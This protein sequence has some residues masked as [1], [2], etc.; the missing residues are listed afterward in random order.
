KADSLWGSVFSPSAACMVGE[1]RRASN[2]GIG[3]KQLNQPYRRRGPMSGHQMLT[4]LALCCLGFTVRAVIG[5][6][7]HHW[8]WYWLGGFVSVGCGYLARCSIEHLARSIA[9][10]LTALAVGHTPRLA[11]SF[12]PP[13]VVIGLGLVTRFFAIVAPRL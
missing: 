12:E 7:K 8:G 5:A 13:L 9:F 4:L 1:S 10:A 11:R 6:I 2:G 3:P